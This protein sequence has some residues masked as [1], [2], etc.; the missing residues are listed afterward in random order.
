MRRRLTLCEGQSEAPWDSVKKLVCHQQLPDAVNVDV[1]AEVAKNSAPTMLSSLFSVHRLC[2]WL[3]NKFKVSFYCICFI[4][5]FPAGVFVSSTEL[6]LLTFRVRVCY[7]C[8]DHPSNS[9]F[10]STVR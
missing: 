10:F 6:F 5:P 7:G 3:S 9:S 4:F 1:P 2:N 8:T